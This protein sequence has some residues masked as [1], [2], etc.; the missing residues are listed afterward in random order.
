MENIV[1][2]LESGLQG[3]YKF[4]IDLK[5]KF[6][7]EIVSDDKSEHSLDEWNEYLSNQIFR[8]KT[9]YKVWTARPN[10]NNVTEI[11]A[12]FKLCEQLDEDISMKM[13]E[14]KYAHD[15]CQEQAA[16]DAATPAAAASAAAVDDVDAAAVIHAPLWSNTRSQCVLPLVQ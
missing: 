11:K 5:K 7:V 9:I 2:H 12:F 3:V 1:D 4:G 6:G 15:Y 8:L 13:L 14:C 10:S 16:D